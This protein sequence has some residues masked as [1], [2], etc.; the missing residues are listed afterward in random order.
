[1]VTIENVSQANCD[2]HDVIVTNDGGYGSTLKPGEKCTYHVWSPH[3]KLTI[4]EVS[5]NEKH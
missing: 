1:M 3:G 4:K 2:G 5:E